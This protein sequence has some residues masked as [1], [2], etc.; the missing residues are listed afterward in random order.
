MFRFLQ[1][2][3]RDKY[4]SAKDSIFSGKAIRFYGKPMSASVVGIFQP[5]DSEGYSLLTY[6]WVFHGLLSPFSM[7]FNHKK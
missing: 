2:E 4:L 6:K 1:A 7:R 3:K 5:D